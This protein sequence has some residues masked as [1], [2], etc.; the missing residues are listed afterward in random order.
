MRDLKCIFCQF[1]TYLIQ[2]LLRDFNTKAG[3]ILQQKYKMGL[4]EMEQRKF[5]ISKICHFNIVTYIA[6]LDFSLWNDT[7]CLY[8]ILTDTKEPQI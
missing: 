1:H 4:N 5:V 6:H 8:H 2:I 7:E 3:K